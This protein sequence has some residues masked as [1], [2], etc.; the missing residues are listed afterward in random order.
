[1]EDGVTWCCNKPYHSLYLEK[2]G[3][4]MGTRKNYGLSVSEIKDLPFLGND[5]RRISQEVHKRYRVRTELSEEDRSPVAIYYPELTCGKHM[6]YKKRKLPK[7]FSVVKTAI[8]GV[9]DYFGQH[10]CPLSGKV[11]LICAGEE[12]TLAAYQMLSDRYPDWDHAVVGLPRG[13][14]TSTETVAENLD[15]TRNFESVILATIWMRRDARP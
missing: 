7:A 10:Q 1:M 14:A 8:T 13:E 11:L 4:E 3:E 6:G 2:E 9:P 12:D 15:F 5:D